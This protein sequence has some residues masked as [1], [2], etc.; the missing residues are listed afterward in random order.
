M[1]FAIID[2]LLKETI[3]IICFFLCSV[4]LYMYVVIHAFECSESSYIILVR[5][6]R[7]RYILNRNRFCSE[8]WTSN[9]FPL[10]RMIMNSPV[11]LY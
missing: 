9:V 5:A 10:T 11:S 1:F 4:K 2:I 6:V 3:I 7:Y 8:N